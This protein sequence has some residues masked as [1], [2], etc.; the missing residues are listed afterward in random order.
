MGAQALGFQVPGCG[1]AGRGV[2]CGQSWAGSSHPGQQH[3]SNLLNEVA[4]LLPPLHQ[5]IKEQSCGGTVRIGG[6]VRTPKIVY[7]AWWELAGVGVQVCLPDPWSQW[8]VPLEC[9]LRGLGWG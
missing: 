9:E 1:G 7:R 3:I 6:A 5:A 4:A 8:A 2:C